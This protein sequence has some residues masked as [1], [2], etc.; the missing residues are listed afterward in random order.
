M[1]QFSKIQN[2]LTP[3]FLKIPVSDTS[4]DRYCTRSEHELRE[5]K[6]NSDGYSAS[7]YPDSVRYWNRIDPHLR[8]SSTLSSFKM[9]LFAGYRSPPKSVYGINDPIGTRIL[10][11]L[12]LGLSPLFDHKKK[13][14]FIDTP[15]NTCPNCNIPETLEHFLLF[16]TS[17][18]S[19]RNKLIQDILLLHHDIHS[20]NPQDK[21][22]FLLYG[23]TELSFAT[24]I[25]VLKVTLNFIKDSQRFSS[26]FNQ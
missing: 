7:F 11:Q 15:S 10:F 16:C 19:Y 26:H 20:L 5:I 9:R 17:F 2:D 12:R 8:N 25:S 24:N 1:I 3:A 23:D 13:H 14:N 22:K 6:C 18:T 21:T 4:S